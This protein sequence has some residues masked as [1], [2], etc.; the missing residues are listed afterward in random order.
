MNYDEALS[1][2]HGI[3]RY[4]T[5]PGLT[6][7]ENLLHLMGD[8]HKQLRYVHVAGTN[9]KGSTVAMCRSV[10]SHAGFRTG[11][12]VSP[13]LE[14]FNERIQVEGVPIPDEELVALTEETK[15]LCDEM[16]ARGMLHPTEFE[17][18]TAMAFRYWL[19]KGCDYVA[20]EVGM[21]G[22]LDATNVIPAPAAAIITTIAKDHT[23]YLGD[24]LT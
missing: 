2:I 19:S 1:Y 13:F 5:K 10:L 3:K 17:V 18:V 9:G 11:S 16:T 15:A 21:G 24:T 14:R 23:Q 22:R 6:R 12:F 4:S 8:P 20:L 7:I